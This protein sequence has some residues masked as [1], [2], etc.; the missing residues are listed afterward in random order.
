MGNR[1]GLSSTVFAT[2]LAVLAGLLLAAADPSPAA[3]ACGTGWQSKKEPPDSILVLR[4][5]TGQVEEVGFKRYVAVVMASGE[6][7]TSLPVALLEAGA[8]ATKQYAWYYALEGNHRDGYQN[9]AGSCYD[10]RD[11]HYDQ[12]YRPETAEPTD[13][14]KAARDE[15]WGLSLRKNDKFFLTAYRQGSATKCAQDHDEWKLYANS[16]RDCAKRLGYDGIEI[17]HAY[18][19]PKLTDVW[20]PGTEPEADDEEGATAEPEAD[21][22]AQADDEARADQEPETDDEQAPAASG[23]DGSTGSTPSLFDR[24]RSWFEGDDQA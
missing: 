17:L 6:W 21:D 13:K 5:A 1:A 22:E 23:D 7:P 18:Y 15:L 16:A 3:A 19:S 12:V 2:A 10:V 9:A 11:D 4:T 20:A 14:Q 8:L 24:V